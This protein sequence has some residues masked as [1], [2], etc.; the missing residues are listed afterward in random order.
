MGLASSIEG[1]VWGAV[2]AHESLLPSLIDRAI[3]VRQA[4]RWNP[5]IAMARHLAISEH[6]ELPA[7]FAFVAPMP[8]TERAVGSS[9]A[10]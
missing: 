3:A 9:K 2:S 5:A 4:K 6:A 1:T 7:K 8:A 10:F